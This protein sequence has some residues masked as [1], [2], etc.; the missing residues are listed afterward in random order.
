MEKQITTLTPFE[1][2]LL[3][4][5]ISILKHLDPENANDYDKQIK[6]LHSGYTIMYS[7][8]FRAL[9]EEIPV[10][11]CKYV[12]DVLNM[13]RTL[14][15]SF[16]GLNDKQGLT[17]DDVAF[18]GFDGNNET[19]RLAFAEY[20]LEKPGWQIAL[21][22]GLDSHSIATMSLYPQMLARYEPIKRALTESPT[23]NFQLTAEQ[24]K[25]VIGWVAHAS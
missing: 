10:D 21:R 4:N 8:L 24:I 13:H 15:K 2:L 20:L 25:R 23:S 17:K 14:V 11:E 22:N 7:E 5:Q 9:F 16:E 3:L 18:R 1:R 19:Q 12:L 6:I